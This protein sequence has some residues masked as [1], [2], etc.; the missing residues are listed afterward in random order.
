[1]SRIFMTR[2]RSIF[3]FRINHFNFFSSKSGILDPTETLD[4]V[5]KILIQLNVPDLRR[6]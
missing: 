3:P 2:D 5:A 6:Q 1:M 4:I